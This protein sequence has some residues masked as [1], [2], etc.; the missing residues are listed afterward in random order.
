MYANSV[1]SNFFLLATIGSYLMLV[2][3]TFG[4]IIFFATM[5]NLYNS[6]NYSV[7][8]RRN[9]MASCAPSAPNSA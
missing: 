4:G 7:Q 3:Y 8:A 9:Y 1:Y 6:V 2:L 5:L